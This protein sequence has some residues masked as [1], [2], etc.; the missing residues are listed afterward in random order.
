MTDNPNR[1]ATYI[2]RRIENGKLFHCFDDQKSK[3][4][5]WFPKVKKNRFAG[6]KIGMQ[7]NMPEGTIPNYWPD[8]EVGFVDELTVKRYEA[9][10]RSELS[11]DNAR[12][13]KPHPNLDRIVSEL[14][15]IR[16]SLNVSQRKA[17]DL[18]LIQ[19]LG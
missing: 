10:D 2:G 17:F 5:F 4:T 8:V 3:R 11:L 9:A 19:S 16:N 15:T 12:K 6:I 13:I 7:Y 18:W 14:A 1:I